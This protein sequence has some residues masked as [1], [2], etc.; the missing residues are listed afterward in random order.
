MQRRMRT[1]TKQKGGRCEYFDEF[2][3][4]QPGL[5]DEGRAGVREEWYA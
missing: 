1:R 3:L 5:E 4:E 2:V